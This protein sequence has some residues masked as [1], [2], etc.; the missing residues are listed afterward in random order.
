[1][2]RNGEAGVIESNSISFEEN[3]AICLE[4]EV[5][6]IEN[7]YE[8]SI[9]SWRKA[10]L[11]K[12]PETMET[13]I[14]LNFSVQD[15]ENYISYSQPFFLKSEF[16]SPLVTLS[17]RITSVKISFIECNISDAEDLD[18]FNFIQ[19][20]KKI[21]PICLINNDAEEKVVQILDSDY[22]FSFPFFFNESMK[23]NFLTE[24]E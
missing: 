24:N 3:G 5:N 17:P 23:E 11:D 1:L 12:K 7:Y 8:E 15:V 2:K 18:Q 4:I 14:D 19:N 10:F 22:C 20:D 9:E 16:F 6:G 13:Y 21:V